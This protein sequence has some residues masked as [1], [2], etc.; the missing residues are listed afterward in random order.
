L[1]YEKDITEAW[2]YRMPFFCYKG[3]MFC[4]L[5]TNKKTGSP[6]LGMVDGKLLNHPWLIAENPSIMT[7]LPIDATKDIPVEMIGGILHMAIDIC[8]KSL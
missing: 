1:G 8:N 3:K 5:W 4:Y 6:Y 7:I 2:K